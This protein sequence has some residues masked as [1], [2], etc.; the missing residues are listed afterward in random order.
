MNPSDYVK[1][2]Q[3]NLRMKH[4]LTPRQVMDSH[5][6]LEEGYNYIS[7]RLEENYDDMTPDA[8]D[9]ANKLQSFLIVFIEHS[10]N[11]ALLKK[12]EVS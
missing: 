2:L 7:K 9:V 3:N 1:I 10:H 11:F 6:F 4:V 12:L 8:V 5:K